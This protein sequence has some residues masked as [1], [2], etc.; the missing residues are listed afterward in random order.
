[1]RRRRRA[2]TMKTCE[3]PLSWSD[4]VTYW[5]HDDELPISELNRIEEHVMGCG[6]CS[7]D[8]EIA[9]KLALA[10]RDYLPP[11]VT[12]AH[13]GRLRDRGAQIVENIFLPSERKPAVFRPND[14]L[15]IHRLTGIDLSK[16]D[17]VD[18]TV[19]VE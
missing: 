12:R 14:D 5:A 19:R 6:S 3:A 10:V 1:M 17:R 7:A 9:A 15:L 8:S 11:A 2:G 16:A 4:L 13:V 18:L